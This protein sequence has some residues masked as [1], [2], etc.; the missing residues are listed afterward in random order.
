MAKAVVITGAS[1]GIGRATAHRFA[2][3]GYRLALAARRAAALD[4]VAEECRRRGAEAIAV[5]TDVTDPGQMRH[6]AQRAIATF[7]GI[8]VWFNNAGVFL[9]GRFENKSEAQFRRVIETNLFGYVHGARAVLPHFRARRRGI[10]INN[11]SLAARTGLPLATAYV[12][13]KFAIRGFS[14]ALREELAAEP[15]IAVCTVLPASIDTPLWQHSGNVSG[16]AIR[17][18]R[19]AYDPD[20]VARAV[21]RLARHPRR[22]VIVGAFGKILAAQHHWLP[23]LGERVMGF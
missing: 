23:G 18:L 12:A 9:L 8:D 4:D 21:L 1:S 5:P 19:P 15:R 3:A 16:R 14:L 22:E 6:L 17:P 11:A 2:E 7:G 10:L 20:L 13:S